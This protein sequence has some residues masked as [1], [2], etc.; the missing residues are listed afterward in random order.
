[1][2]RKASSGHKKP[3]SEN[4]TW[5]YR[6]FWYLAYGYFQNEHFFNSFLANLKVSLSRLEDRLYKKEWENIELKKPIFIIGPHRSGTTILQQVL[7]MHT[8]VATP[9]TY[10][11]MFDMI[12]ILAKKYLRPLIR[13]R[14]YR[15]IDRIVVG[16]D[17]PQEAQGLI[18]R[19]FD[20]ERVLYNPTTPD[21]L[22]NYMRKLLYLERKKRFLWKVPYLT[23]QIPEIIKLFP[24]AR[25]IYIHRDPVACVDSK[26]KFIKVW[27]EMAQSP[28]ILYHHLVGR[29]QH[30]DQQGLGYFMEQANRTVNLR[31]T[32]PDPLAIATDHLKWIEQALRDLSN[33]GSYNTRCFLDYSTL[34][35][36]PQ[37]S[38]RRLFEFLELPD[39][40]EAIL[41][42]LEELGMPL[43]MP[44]RK[45]SHLPKESIPAI[46]EECR[47]RMKQCC[48]AVDWKGW[49]II[50]SIP[51]ES[52]S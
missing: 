41:A 31:H 7:S 6:L 12:P 13:G 45:L 9:R 44:E 27:Q 5:K 39:E 18:S 34:V 43:V 29:N 4:P 50:G 32:V 26:L 36:E 25:F 24:D 19:Y 8:A 40:S 15:R 33:L 11:D 48:S 10:S 16:F 52:H 49:Q 46:E 30:L 38:L 17:T 35:L 1:M 23:I 42:N 3:E 20:K 2:E 37:A 21:E 28:S 51:A 47:E 14:A 22:R